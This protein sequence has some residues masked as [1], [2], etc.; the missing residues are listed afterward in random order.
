M[1]H[2]NEILSDLA[3]NLL[4]TH[5]ANLATAFILWIKALV[6]VNTLSSGVPVTFIPNT[7]HLVFSS[8]VDGEAFIRDGIV[9]LGREKIFHV[10]PIPVSE[11]PGI[12]DNG[13]ETGVTLLLIDELFVPLHPP[14]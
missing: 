6:I 4:E 14:C 7:T 13:P 10:K 1:M 12:P 8:L 5:L 3:V 9:R 11:I 2:F